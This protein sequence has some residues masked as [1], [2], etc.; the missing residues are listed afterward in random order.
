MKTSIK[1]SLGSL[2]AIVFMF[3][4]SAFAAAPG[5]TLDYICLGAD[6]EITV[7]GSTGVNKL[8]EAWQ[9]TLWSSSPTQNDLGTFPSATTDE[10]ETISGACAELDSNAPW[11]ILVHNASTDYDS[12][13]ITSPN[14]SGTG[15]PPS[16]GNQATYGYKIGFVQ[17]SGET[18]ITAQTS[19]LQS[20]ITPTQNPTF[21][22]TFV[23][24]GNEPILMEFSGVQI[25]EIEDG[26]EYNTSAIENTI[27]STGN[28][29]YNE[30]FPLLTGGAYAWRPYLRSASSTAFVFGE[31]LTFSV[32]TQNGLAS[33]YTPLGDNVFST[34]TVSTFCEDNF[35][36]DDSSIISMTKTAI[37]A[38]LCKV[39]AFLFI[40][41]DTALTQFSSLSTQIQ[42]AFPFSYM[43]GIK[44][45]WD[46]LAS[47]TSNGAPSYTFNFA[48]LGL[49]STT[50]MGNILPN[51]VAFSS[52]TV[53]QYFPAGTFDLL[54]TLAGLAILLT[55]FADIFFT[56]RNLIR[57]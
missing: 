46:Q 22:F 50:P 6:M 27:N 26:I 13:R 29:S 19:P 34:S 14:G 48:S 49:G 36:Y 15:S 38:G 51:A 45:T 23:E 7:T 57:T 24:S 9:G 55:L 41:P 5:W 8:Y 37:P 17:P 39:T 25:K 44:N 3:P 33:P 40:P 10:T 47:S 11:F 42:Q 12:W 30:T 20:S 21:A 32:V 4:F 56:V 1:L 35:P 53:T 18:R 54:K 43:Y 31:W 16:P 28:L 2:F 52:S